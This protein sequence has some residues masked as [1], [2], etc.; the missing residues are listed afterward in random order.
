MDHNWWGRFH[1]W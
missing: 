1:D